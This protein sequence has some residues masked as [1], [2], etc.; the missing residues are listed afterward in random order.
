GRS[1]LAFVTALGRTPHTVKVYVSRGGHQTMTLSV[2]AGSRTKDSIAYGVAPGA[3]VVLIRNQTPDGRW[4]DFIE[5][6][7]EA[8]KRPEVDLLSDSA[9]IVMVPDTAADFAGLL[10]HRIVAAY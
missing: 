2:A 7:L 4:R 6:Y 8:A 1:D 10:F 3:R 9:G 5:G